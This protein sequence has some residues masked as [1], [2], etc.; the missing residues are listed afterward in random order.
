MNMRYFLLF[1]GV[2]AMGCSEK[3]VEPRRAAQPVTIN[4]THSISVPAPAR[5][6]VFVPNLVAAWRG[7]I[8]T[9]DQSGQIYSADIENGAVQKLPRGNG[10]LPIS[11][12]RLEALYQKGSA[13]A[14]LIL[15]K[16]A[17]SAFIEAD[18]EGV[19]AP[20]PFSQTGNEIIALCPDFYPKPGT[21]FGL[22][23][24]GKIGKVDYAIH[25]PKD[26]G[27]D[28]NV[29]AVISEE[30]AG[31]KSIDSCAHKDG[32]LYARAN[33]RLFV[34][35]EDGWEAEPISAPPSLQSPVLIGNDP[36][37]AG[38]DEAGTVHLYAA[39][40]KDNDYR[41][42]IED[43]FLM[44]GLARAGSVASTAHNFGTV[45]RD[46]FLMAA[47]PNTGRLVFIGTEYLSKEIANK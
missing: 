25:A 27:T 21:A 9:A 35:N 23:Q 42:N 1:A 30:I 26:D 3:P 14:V 47:D 7:R 17:T 8:I 11:Q 16:N 46:G 40:S 20:L 5:Q 12:I 36:Y 4:V 34:R 39:N 33:D 41:L 18:D 32:I 19:F 37:F 24:S 28:Q 13:G 6:T 38:L 22:L 2:L 43:S 29:Q 15:S 44:P 31:P 45:F 10:A